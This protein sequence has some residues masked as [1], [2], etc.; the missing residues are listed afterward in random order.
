MKL[1]SLAAAA[2][3]LCSASAMAGI[4]VGVTGSG[5]DAEVWA[6]V[7]DED[8]GTYAID[9]GITMSELF[10][11]TSNITLGKAEGADWEAYVK[12]DGNLNDFEQFAGTRWGLFAVQSDG[13]AFFPDTI[14]F[15]S[16]SYLSEDV[17]LPNDKA[18]SRT[19][20]MANFASLLNQNGLSP[21]VTKNLDAFNAKGF[22]GHFIE[23][24]DGPFL[25]AGNAIGTS[26]S[27]FMC[28]VSGFDAGAPAN[29]GQSATLRSVSFDGM[30]FTATA[31]PEPG[32]YALMAAGLLAVGAMVRR[33]RG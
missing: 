1:K 16:T 2:A 33:R 23:S 19:S 10:S 6:M 9:F 28:G 31:V 12:A 26:S 27:V 3:V 11:A 32:T 21:D 14:R 7:W 29:C 8:K 15:L 18:E 13:L 4:N 25:F 20:T 22:P 17:Q 30:N 5:D 24:I